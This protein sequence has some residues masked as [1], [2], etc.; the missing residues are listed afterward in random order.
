MGVWGSSVPSSIAKKRRIRKRRKAFTVMMHRNDLLLLINTFNS[1]FFA[2]DA[3]SRTLVANDTS[4]MS[5][6]FLA[7]NKAHSSKLKAHDDRRHVFGWNFRLLHGCFS[8]TASV[9]R[10]FVS[11]KL[12][13]LNLLQHNCIEWITRKILSHRFNRN[14]K[15]HFSFHF[16]NKLPLCSCLSF[17]R[18]SL[19]MKKNHF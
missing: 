14:R 4:S 11:Y 12:R 3:F 5:R 13:W 10:F 9:E 8:H 2:V 18:A 6:Q 17:L 15:L 19:C 1:F 7:N 16:Y